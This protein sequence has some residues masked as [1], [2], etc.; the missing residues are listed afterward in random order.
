MANGFPCAGFEVTDAAAI[1]EFARPEQVRAFC[2]SPEYQAIP[3][4][5]PRPA[6]GPVPLLTDAEQERT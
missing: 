6:K 5:R 1:V 3:P 2:D 4:H